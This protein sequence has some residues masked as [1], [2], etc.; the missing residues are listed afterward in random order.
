LSNTQNAGAVTESFKSNYFKGRNL[1]KLPRMAYLM[2]VHWNW[3][4]QRPHFIFEQL[5]N[6]YDIDLY[7]V[8]RLGF[9]Y[10]IQNKFPVISHGNYI[11]LVKLPYSAR[12]LCIHWLERIINYNKLCG[13][14]DYQYIW[15]T[16]PIMLN[17][18]PEDY[19]E[20]KIV[21]YDCMDDYLEF[22]AI[23][24]KI[25][26]HKNLERKLII[27]SKLIFTSSAYLKQKILERYKEYITCDP[28]CVY[29]AIS[30]D[31]IKHVN[32]STAGLTSKKT[33]IN[34]MYVGTVAEWIDF[35]LMLR[36]LDKLPNIKITLIGPIEI[37]IPK[38]PRLISQGP[39]EHHRLP[40][41]A[42]NADAFIMPFVRNE[43]VMSVNP[44]KIYE[45]LSFLKPIICIRTKETE[46]FLPYVSLYSDETEII[47]I[48]KDIDKLSIAIQNQAKE[49]K[50]FLAGNTWTNRISE[51]TRA[52]SSIKNLER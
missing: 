33:L 17:F 29:N 25:E 19:L 4:K 32:T 1:L 27:K 13:K 50:K 41:V 45:Y 21:I 10:R 47:K 37:K 15:I 2:H 11:E 42:A 51:I 8:K 26:E 5:S 46:R 24:K 18:I 12:L 9:R 34:L 52:I 36:V 40:E 7:C 14:N 35:A 43:L 23:K 16:S 48:L 3:I 31:F 38:H 20:G 39:V 28:I 6:F 30:E 49:I 44:V 22:N